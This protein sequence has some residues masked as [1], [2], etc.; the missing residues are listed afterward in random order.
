MKSD[1][2]STPASPCAAGMLAHAG[3]VAG[4][5]AFTV[6]SPRAERCEDCR[7]G[8]A[9][10]ASMSVSYPPQTGGG[11]IDFVGWN[12]P[13]PGKIAVIELVTARIISDGESAGLRL[14]AALGNFNS[15]IDFVLTPQGQVNG[16][17]IWVATHAV[18]I[19]TDKMLTFNVYRAGTQTKGHAL[20]CVSGYLAD[21]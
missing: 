21:A 12:L 4:E 20:V 13:P 9:F 2:D 1:L 3:Q 7:A 11:L 8:H 10:H 6:R 17:Q 16:Q 18:R 5:Q 15:N 14:F 19:C